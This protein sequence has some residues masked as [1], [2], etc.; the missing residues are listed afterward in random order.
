M[1]EKETNGE[2]VISEKETVKV[3]NDEKK[4]E[5]VFVK[6]GDKAELRFV[7]TGIQDNQNIEILDGLKPGDEI[8]IGPYSVVSKTLK[9]GDKV[10]VKGEQIKK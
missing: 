5:A 7:K 2:E 4:F 9:V 1:S 3:E 10:S 6:N 8:I